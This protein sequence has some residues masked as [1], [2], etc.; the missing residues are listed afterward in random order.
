MFSSVILDVGV[1][2]IFAFLAVSLV[3]SAVTEALASMLKWRSATLLTGIKNLLNDDAFGGLAR[4][5]YNHALVSPRAD[6]KASTEKELKDLPSYVDPKQFAGA[7]IDVAK[8][9]EDTPASM[10]AAIDQNVK[11]PQLNQLLKGIVDRTGGKLDRLQGEIG[12]WFDAAMD[13]VGGAYKRKTQLCSFIIALALAVC[14]N[15]DTVHIAKALWQQPMLA[16]AIEVKPIETPEQALAKLDALGLPIGWTKEAIDRISKGPMEIP[17]RLLGWFITA[18][19]TLFGAS[20]WFDALQRVTRLKG[21]GPS[22]AEKKLDS[23]AAA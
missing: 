5:I 14:L 19:A 22:P 20:F 2:L 11:D 1:G 6:G 7:L 13:R 17:V 15:V 23:G 18:I 21:S 4:N 9:V 12:T 8:I 3:S 10:K 16:K